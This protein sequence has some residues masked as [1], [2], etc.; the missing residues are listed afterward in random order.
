MLQRSITIGLILL[1]VLFSIIGSIY[2]VP[3]Q[4][5]VIPKME[6][7][8]EEAVLTLASEDDVETEEEDGDTTF[9]DSKVKSCDMCTSFKNNSVYVGKSKYK[10][11]GVFAARKIFTGEKVE[12]CPILL[13]MK[14]RIPQNNIMIDYVFSTGVDGEVALAMGYCGLFNHDDNH[15]ARWVIDREKRTVTIIALR[16]IYADEEIYVSYGDKYWDTR[17]YKKDQV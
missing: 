12:V 5:F 7:F 8:E 11:R 13:E 16:D 15:N 6:S 17:G 14:D 10:G 2:K 9:H 4:Q 1:I 3:Q